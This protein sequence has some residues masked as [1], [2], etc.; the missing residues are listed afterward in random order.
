MPGLGCF[1][2]SIHEVGA[3]WVLRKTTGSQRSMVRLYRLTWDRL[4]CPGALYDAYEDAV[5]FGDD[6]A[7]NQ[8][9]VPL[10]PGGGRLRLEFPVPLAK[11]DFDMQELAP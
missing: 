6:P 5:R 10:R 9:A 3:G 1:M 4:S 8:I 2:S 11:S 7:R